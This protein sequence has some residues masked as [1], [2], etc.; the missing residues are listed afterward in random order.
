MDEW[1][2]RD[3]ADE[4]H[5]GGRE[6]PAVAK[7]AHV[8][9][10]RMMQV[11]I[12]HDYY[13]ADENLCTD[14]VA[15]PTPPSQSLIRSLSLVFQAEPTGFSILYDRNR[16]PG[17]CWYLREHGIVLPPGGLQYWM[18]LSFVLSLQTAVFANITDIPIETNATQQ[19]FYFSNQQAHRPPAQVSALSDPPFEIA[20]LNP[21]ERVTGA[22]L[23]PLGGPEVQVVTPPEVERVVALDIAGQEVKSEP[24]CVRVS[25]SPPEEVC[26]DV[27]FLDLRTCPEDKYTIESLTAEGPLAVQSIV[28]TVSKPPPFCFVDL[29]F[30]QPA[31]GSAGIYPLDLQT[32][33]CQ[34][35]RY[36]LRFRARSTYWRYYIMP[37]TERERLE[38]LRIETMGDG[39]PVSFA[40]PR[41]IRLPTGAPAYLFESEIPLMLQQ[42]SRYRFRLHGWTRRARRAGDVLVPRLPVA[43]PAQVLPEDGKTWSDIYVTV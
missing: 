37:Q 4:R 33:S 1:I 22:S 24:R 7:T 12:L 31:A 43:S 14:F 39:P 19:N 17:L 34:S 23:L 40:G 6:A 29:L 16:L 18:R 42:R 5:I 25:Q 11:R 32:D 41:R 28:Y 8:R 9:Y 20:L 27:V 2:R 38:D 3:R 15:S 21:G 30:S 35:M 10:A 13:N 26:R 36:L